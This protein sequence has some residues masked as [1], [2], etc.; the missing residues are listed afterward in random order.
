MSPH[1]SRHVLLHVCCAPDATVPWPELTAEGREVAGF[2]YG[3]NIHP[4]QEWQLRRD[5]VLKFAGIVGGEIEISP[6]DPDSWMSAARGRRDSPEGGDGCAAC[7]ELQL[8]AAARFA[9]VRGYDELCTTLTVSPH[10][11]PALINGIG[12]RVSADAGVAWIERVWRKRDGFKISVAR[13]IELGL[14]R[15]KYCGCV[16][17]ERR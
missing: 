7:F 1:P 12:A 4:L 15:Q 16:Y 3:S 14:Y 8:G 10:K 5:A 11:N 2:F 9:A 17:S 6:Y 13:S